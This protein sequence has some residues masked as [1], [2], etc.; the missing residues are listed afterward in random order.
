MELSIYPAYPMDVTP[1]QWTSTTSVQRPNTPQH[2][3]ASH[4]PPEILIHVLRQLHTPRD[5]RNALLVSRSW[6]ECAVELLWHRPSFSGVSRFRMML[7]IISSDDR[8]FDYAKFVRRL[9][10]IY[11]GRELTDSLFVR[12]SRCVKLERLTLVNCVEITDEALQKVL[13]LCSNLVALDLTNITS[14]SD[15]TIIALARAA[16]KL[17]GINLGGCKNITDEGVLALADHCPLIRRIKLSNVRNI[18][19]RSVTAI[20]KQC[21][22]LLEIDLNGCPK[23]TDQAIRELWVHST[24]LRDFRL[25]QCTELTDLAFPASP[26]TATVEVQQN[27]IQPFPTAANFVPIVINGLSPLYPKHM[28]EHLRM[29]DLTSCALV[30]DEAIAG[31]IANAPKIRNLVL[32]KCSQLTDAA[33]ESICKLGKHLH[34]LHLGHASAIT[35]KCIRT[36]TRSCT[37]LRYI[38]LACAL[39]HICRTRETLTFKDRLSITH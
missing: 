25:S 17:Q 26:Q 23:V 6:C 3:P 28:C 9:N 33:V 1:A 34:Y 5:L 21:P 8:T 37:R 13:P 36:L 27:G 4:L 20:A 12:L 31:I 29:L 39:H 10:F 18:T 22:L 15:K 38:D 7:Q 16:T 32:A 35:D 19:D 24:C 30:T 2:S 11:L 14:C